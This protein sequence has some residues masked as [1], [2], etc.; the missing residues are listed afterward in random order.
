MN[1][2]SERP[3]TFRFSLRTLLLCVTF[4]AIWCAL[5]PRTW[6]SLVAAVISLSAVQCFSRAVR[7][8]H[9]ILA[10]VLCAAT[11]FIP[12]VILMSTTPINDALAGFQWF[13][14]SLLICVGMAVSLGKE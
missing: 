5:A 11:F 4:F 14:L 7:G 1:G 2:E 8:R 6:G 12:L 3:S 10:F 9:L 13:A